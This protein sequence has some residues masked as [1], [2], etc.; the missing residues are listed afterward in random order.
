VFVCGLT[1]GI[2]AGKSVVSR[3]LAELGAAV[4]DADLLAREAVAPGSPGLA[5]VV[6]RFGPSV[7]R[8]DGSL[9]RA[10]LGAVVTKF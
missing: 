2:A 1:G 8:P 4:V 7:I 10:A 6:E 3:R 9:D 5:R